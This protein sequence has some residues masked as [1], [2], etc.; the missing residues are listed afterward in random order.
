MNYGQQVLSRLMNPGTL[1]IV[2]GAV[3]VYGSGWISRR[4]LP[5]KGENANLICK[6]IG[7]MIAIIG[8]ILTLGLIH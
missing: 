6:A 7:V 4:F 1:L 5:D 8:T 2:I 3:V